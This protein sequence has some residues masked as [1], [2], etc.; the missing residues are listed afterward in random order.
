MV[1]RNRKRVC[2]HEHTLYFV[3]FVG[4]GGLE[5]PMGNNV[6][7]FPLAT[8]FIEPVGMSCTPVDNFTWLLFFLNYVGA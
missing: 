8:S 2:A 4:L 1:E 3:L 7:G 5:N 6:V